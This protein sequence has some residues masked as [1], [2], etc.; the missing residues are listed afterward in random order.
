MIH[1]QRIKKIFAKF[2]NAS[3]MYHNWLVGCHIFLVISKS[4]LIRNWFLRLL[5]FRNLHTRIF[6]IKHCHVQCVRGT[7]ESPLFGECS[8]IKSFSCKY[9]THSEQVKT[10]PAC[11]CCVFL[12]NFLFSGR[13]FPVHTPTMWGLKKTT[14]LVLIKSTQFHFYPKHRPCRRNCRKFVSF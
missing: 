2:L 11:G 13:L 4:N 7:G 14:F 1:E 12:F 3:W 9:V 10:N 6:D 8:S 5:K